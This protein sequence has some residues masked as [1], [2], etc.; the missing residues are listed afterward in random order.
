[1]KAIILLGNNSGIYA[2]PN[3]TVAN[4]LA[5]GFSAKDNFQAA[6]Y[7]FDPSAFVLASAMTKPL[8]GWRT[9]PGQIIDPTK[10]NWTGY[11]LIWL[12]E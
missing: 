10:T 11:S 12:Y 6:S 3:I 1:M 5:L 4:V 8:K 9:G 7:N 2:A